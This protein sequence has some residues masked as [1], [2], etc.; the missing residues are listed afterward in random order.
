M[1]ITPHPDKI[2]FIHIP[3]T[4]GTSVEQWLGM[5]KRGP[6]SLS[7]P[8]PLHDYLANENLPLVGL[9]HYTF[10]DI[11]NFLRNNQGRFWCDELLN[12]IHLYKIFT[13]VRNPWAKL[14][15][16]WWWSSKPMWNNHRRARHTMPRQLLS[17]TKSFN[18]FVKSI[19][20]LSDEEIKYTRDSHLRPQWQFIISNPDHSSRDIILGDPIRVAR[21]EMYHE[22]ISSMFAHL[23]KDYRLQRAGGKYSGPDHNL[24]LSDYAIDEIGKIYREDIDLFGYDGPDS[25]PKNLDLTGENLTNF[26]QK[27]TLHLTRWQKEIEE[28]GILK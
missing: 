21:Y 28:E 24:V 14:V 7:G 5:Y 10:L 9:Q 8:V 25:M 22:D 11:I 19:G 15:S 17:L 16:H 3:R 26:I 1:P 4:G 23:D 6:S 20:E 13:I 18:K 12:D 27:D 2:L